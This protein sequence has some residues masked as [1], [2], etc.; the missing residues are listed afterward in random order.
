[1]RVAAFGSDLCALSKKPPRELICITPAGEINVR[2]VNPEPGLFE[3]LLASTESG[4]ITMSGGT[5]RRYNGL[6]KGAELVVQSAGLAADGRPFVS[7]RSGS[8]VQLW[9]GEG[10]PLRLPLPTDVPALGAFRVVSVDGNR[11]LVYGQDK[12]FWYEDLNITD[13]FKVDEISYREEVFPHFWSLG[14][15]LRAVGQP[16]GSLLLSVSGPAGVALM[17]LR[18]PVEGGDDI[19]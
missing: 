9:V 7:G 14:T 13:S 15:P 8:D 1:L 11:Y 6:G 3:G 2:D 18:W 12:A 4:L 17:S 5:L 10:P 16:D 19:E